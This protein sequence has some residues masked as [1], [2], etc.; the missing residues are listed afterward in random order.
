MPL[1]KFI[2]NK[3]I[4][5]M[6]EATHG[7]KEFF[8]MKHRMF[9]FL[10]EEMGFTLFA[11]EDDFAACVP[12]NNYIL[13][14]KGTGEEAMA[15]FDKWPWNSQ[16]VLELLKWMRKYN[17][18]TKDEDKKIKFYGFDMQ[19]CLKAAEALSLY[20]HQGN[21]EVDIPEF[22]KG[23]HPVN[24]VLDRPTIENME[25]ILLEMKPAN[26]ISIEYREWKI[27]EH[28]KDMLWQKYWN[29]QNKGKPKRDEYMAENLK[30]ILD[31]EGKDK[32]VMVWTHNGHISKSGGQMG[33]FLNYQFKD[34][35][36]SIGFDFSSGAFN[37]K[38]WS[39]NENG[40]IEEF[41][42]PAFD[43]GYFS[44]VLGKLNK[45]YL[46]L[47]FNTSMQSPAV[48]DWL[49]QTQ[50]IHGVGASFDYESKRLWERKYLLAKEFE[51]MIYIKHTHCQ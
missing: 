20:F 17:K 34:E 46:F 27:A 18:K 9:K 19:Q 5:L 33:G 24:Y 4:V 13:Y 51:A 22:S 38:K 39:E 1:K 43:Q 25:V 49:S 36:Y 41:T 48:Y 2:G 32:K 21:K 50:V 45:N 8:T 29:S 15:N 14:G 23:S 37:S 7:T 28:H 42:L 3:N 40:E 44:D 6:G 47:D 12:I 11:I 35:L 26:E 30:W 31:F 16:E 10:V